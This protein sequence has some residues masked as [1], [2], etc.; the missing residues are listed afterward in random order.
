MTDH[1]PKIDLK[2]RLGKKTVSS[3]TG[4]SIPPPVGLP[5]PSGIPAPPFASRPAAAMDTSNP[6][7]AIDASSAPARIEPQAIKVEMSEEV[8]A[9]QRKQS[10]KF[11]FIAIATAVVGGVLGFAV[12]SGHERSKVADQALRDAS[13]LGKQI[14]D[15][16]GT[17]ETLADTLKAAREQL[18]NGKYPEAEVTKLGE[19][20]VPFGGDK[21]G[22]RNIGRFKKDVTSGLLALASQT[23]KVNDQT[24]SVQRILSGTRKGLQ[25]MF[26]QSATPKVMWAAYAESTPN[27][28]ILNMMALPEPFPMKDKWPESLKLKLEGKDKT[29]KR[30]V[31]GEA[32]AEDPIFIPV[33][34]TT[35]GGVCPQDIAF[36][37]ARQVQELENLLRGGKDATSGEEESGLIEAGRALEEKLKTIGTPG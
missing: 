35:Q 25:D 16:M 7:S 12:G 28:P 32:A 20:R 22:G 19:L 3:P 33:D 30:Y 8:R 26:Q 18:S 34:P 6:Y 4:A 36:R 24:E 29:L 13:E 1:K 10:R 21:L 15:A 11:I 17:A 27:G 5:R 37:V 14:K 2:S 9:E 23:E 31:K